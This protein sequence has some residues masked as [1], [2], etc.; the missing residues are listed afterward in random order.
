MEE[1]IRVLKEQYEEK[2]RHKEELQR[3]A[4]LTELKL[5]RAAKLVSGL[6]G[7]R[8]RWMET[9]EVRT[10]IHTYVHVRKLSVDVCVCVRLCVEMWVSW[11]FSVWLCAGILY[12]CDFIFT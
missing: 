6:A 4:E 8:E 12:V 11:C 10:L 2:L 3:Q 7:E 5:D 9:A 1:K